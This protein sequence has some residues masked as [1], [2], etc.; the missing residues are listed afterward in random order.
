MVPR[1][2]S[3]AG[4]QCPGAIDVEGRADRAGDPVEHDGGE[5]LVVREARAEIAC[6]TSSCA[7]CSGSSGFTEPVPRQGRDRHVERVVSTAAAPRRSVSSGTSGSSSQEVLPPAVGQKER[8]RIEAMPP[9]RE[10]D[11]RVE[12][13]D[14][15]PAAE[16]PRAA[17][18]GPDT[19]SRPRVCLPQPLQ[20]RRVDPLHHP[21][22]GRIGGE[23][24]EQLAL[25]PQR[26][27][28][29][30]ASPPSAIV[31]ARSRSTSAGQCTGTP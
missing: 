23:L 26:G 1:L 18:R 27:Q 17:A 6:R 20:A 15:L 30:Y 3:T 25:I 10:A 21:P 9:L 31:T 28:M 12:V 13:P 24:P 4:T 29:R 22:G 11:G 7:T 16:Q 5:Q 14:Q 19:V 8:Q 2:G